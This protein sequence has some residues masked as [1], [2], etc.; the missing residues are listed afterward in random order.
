MRGVVTLMLLALLSLRYPYP[1]WFAL[2]YGAL[3]AG[4]SLRFDDWGGAL[5]R[6]MMAT[7]F[8]LFFFLI[9]DRTRGDWRYW[10]VTLIVGLTAWYFW[11][12]LV[13]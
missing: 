9:L 12:Y 13:M 11:P 3:V 4:Y 1:Y 10:L 8:G 2:G 6:G 7:A 5:L